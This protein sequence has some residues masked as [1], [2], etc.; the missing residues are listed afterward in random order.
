MIEINPKIYKNFLEITEQVQTHFFN[1]KT[2]KLT[3][4]LESN[5]LS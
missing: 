5:I 1:F 4:K 2:C 3:V